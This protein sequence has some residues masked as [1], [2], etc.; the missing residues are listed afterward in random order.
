MMGIAFW[1]GLFWRRMTVAGAWAAAVVGF[2]AWYLATRQ[3]FIGFVGQLPVAESLRLVWQKAGKAPEIYEPWRI[4]FYLVAATM[5]A[6]V[7]SLLTRPVAREKLDRFYAL[8]RTPIR[9]G[10]TVA[11]A[12]ALPDGVTPPA[13][14]NILPILGLEVPKPSVTSV[15]G[16]LAGWLMV[17][18]LVVG[19]VWLVQQ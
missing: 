5:A 15:V 13:R 16:F 2:G 3:F 1:L 14:P 7:V 10:E 19:F 12:C 11:E 4:T 8:I 9:A 17:A 18:A 6:I